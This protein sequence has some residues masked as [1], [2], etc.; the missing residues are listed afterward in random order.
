MNA[1]VAYGKGYRVE[2]TPAALVEL[3]RAGISAVT[4][5]RDGN[6][7]VAVKVTVAVDLILIDVEG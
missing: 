6:A 4:Y 7:A 3:K 1:I 2:V 5:L